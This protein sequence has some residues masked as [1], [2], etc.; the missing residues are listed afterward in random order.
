[1]KGIVR[2]RKKMKDMGYGGHTLL[3]I[4]AME[5]FDD[6]LMEPLDDR[7]NGA[8]PQVERGFGLS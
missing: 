7:L 4:A 5:P 8:I 1:M 3:A 6:R 2:G